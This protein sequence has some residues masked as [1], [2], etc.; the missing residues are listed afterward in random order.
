MIRTILHDTKVSLKQLLLR[1]MTRL[2]FYRQGSSL[3]RPSVLRN[4]QYLKIGRGV[5]I[6][7]GYRIECY[8]SFA[9]VKLNPLFV[10]GD[11]VIIG[12]G[13]TGF[14]ADKVE[15]KADTIIAGNVTIISENHGIDPES[16]IPYHAQP[17]TTGPVEIGKGCWIGQN[18]S[19]LPNVT[20]G[21][22]CIIGC[23]SVVTK[24]IPSFSIAVGAP[25]E[26]IKQ[27]DFK[28]HKWIKVIR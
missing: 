8:E 19:V 18:V 4:P 1:Q 15:I 2:K 23:N 11:G 26:V 13:F 17:L 5:S 3:G 28:Q 6:K 22:K 24:N 12:P 27:Y 9:N 7:Q 16:D 14:V 20:I 25:A 10:L 21:D